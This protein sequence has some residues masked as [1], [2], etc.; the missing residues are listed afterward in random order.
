MSAAQPYLA[1]QD[2]QDR[3]GNTSRAAFCLENLLHRPA[4]YASR[5]R[6]LENGSQLERANS[7]TSTHDI[8][9]ARIFILSAQPLTV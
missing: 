2:H 4:V 8:I 7:T 1:G 5:S 3:A 9:V 6:S